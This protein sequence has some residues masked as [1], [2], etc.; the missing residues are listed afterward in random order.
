MNK[1]KKFKKLIKSYIKENEAEYSDCKIK[2][3]NYNIY[4]TVC[5]VYFKDKNKSKDNISHIDIP[6]FKF[7]IHL[8]DNPINK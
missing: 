7:L 3:L 5:E 2:I 6:V 4:N 1:N 8:L